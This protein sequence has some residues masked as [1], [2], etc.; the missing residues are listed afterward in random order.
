MSTKIDNGGWYRFLNCIL[1]FLYLVSICINWK[2]IYSVLIISGVSLIFV[3]NMVIG[4]LFMFRDNILEHD[5][6]KK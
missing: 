1:D 3:N 5:S 6:F 2:A 4:K